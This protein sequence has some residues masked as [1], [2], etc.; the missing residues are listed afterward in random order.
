M[1]YCHILLVQKITSLAQIQEER[2]QTPSLD[3]RNSMCIQEWEELLADTFGGSLPLAD[4][5]GW[6]KVDS[7]FMWL[8]W[9]AKN[10]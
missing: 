10:M 7:G 5:W 3:G 2:K 9:K 6:V 4:N 8:A 1:S